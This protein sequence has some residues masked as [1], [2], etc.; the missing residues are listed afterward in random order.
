MRKHKL[1]VAGDRFNRLIVLGEC[2]ISNSGKR[3]FSCLCD[4]GTNAVVVGGNLN[5][6][7][8][9]S[10]GCLNS[11][12]TSTRCTTHGLADTGIYFIWRA[13]ISRCNNPKNKGFKNYGGRGIKVSDHWLKFENFF[14]DMGYKP[15][16]KSLDRVDNDGDYSVEN[17]RWATRK[18]Q[19]NNRRKNLPKITLDGVTLSIGD[20]ANRLKL[21][22]ASVRN[23]LR[24]GVTDPNK[25]LSTSRLPNKTLT[26]ALQC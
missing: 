4:C 18:E 14:E 9:G 11:E 21:N 22:P 8:T 13:L 26:G 10:C 7:T 15:E 16:G 23:R 20:W 19:A 24:K 17:C 1:I 2:G 3:L 6:G 25:L 12:I 5:S